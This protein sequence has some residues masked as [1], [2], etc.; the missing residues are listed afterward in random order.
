MGRVYKTAFLDKATDVMIEF[1]NGPLQVFKVKLT[2]I[3]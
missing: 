2:L 1:W 3:Q